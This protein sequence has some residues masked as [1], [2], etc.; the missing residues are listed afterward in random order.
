MTLNVGAALRILRFFLDMPS[1]MERKSVYLARILHNSTELQLYAL[2]RQESTIRQRNL[3]RQ[4]EAVVK[5]RQGVEERSH[6][7]IS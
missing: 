1:E 7:H 4:P 6:F 3:A 2:H 5:A